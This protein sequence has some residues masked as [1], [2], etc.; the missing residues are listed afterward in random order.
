MGTSSI[1][2]LRVGSLQRS[3]GSPRQIERVHKGGRN[4]SGIEVLRIEYM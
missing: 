2:L 1:M 4:S 3:E